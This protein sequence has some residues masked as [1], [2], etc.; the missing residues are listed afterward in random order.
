MNT[1]D[2]I[3]RELTALANPVQAAHL[4]RFFKTAPGEYG[5]GDRFLGIRVPD[6]RTVVKRHSAGATLAD[7]DTLTL[8]EWHEVRLAGFLTLTDIYHRAARKGDGRLCS[9]AID[10]YLGILD[11]ADNWD[12]VDLSAPKLLGRHIAS[13]PEMM[14]VLDRLSAMEEKL[15]HQRAA[16]V[17]T[18]T[19]IKNDIFEPTLAIA[20]RYLTH[21]HDLIHKAT[22]WMLRECGKRTAG[23]PPMLAFLEAHAAGMPRTMLR[24]AVERL[25]EPRR[26]YFMEARVREAKP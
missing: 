22:G 18:L 7:A 15:W 23:L 9:E 4:M 5:E 11:R 10:L 6:T 25:P 1:A 17:A 24:Y 13:N 19:L 21:S 26:R 20:E 3:T 2:T 8:S 14:P 16:I 12:L